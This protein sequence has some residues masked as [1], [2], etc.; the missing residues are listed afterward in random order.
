MAKTLIVSKTTKHDKYTELIPQIKSLV[1][2][3][4]DIIANTAN[5]SAALKFTFD[6]FWVGWYF[7]KGEELVLGPFQGPIAC[8]RIAFGKGVCGKAWEAGA[9]IMVD[10][11]SKFAGH[12]ACNS[13]SKSEIVMPLFKDGKVVA[14]LDIDSDKLACFDETDKKYLGE[15]LALI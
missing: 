1:S 4:L 2:D 7:V 12:I 6:F 10:D 5:I 15:I 3:E 13:R 8:T 9:P 11:V 14:V